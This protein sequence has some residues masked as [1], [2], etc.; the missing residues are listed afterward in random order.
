MTYL[1]RTNVRRCKIL[2][3][4]NYAMEITLRI[5]QQQNLRRNK[6]RHIVLNAFIDQYRIKS[7]S[8]RFINSHFYILH[9]LVDHRHNKPLFVHEFHVIRQIRFFLMSYTLPIKIKVPI[10]SVRT[11]NV[12]VTDSM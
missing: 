1:I 12:S 11:T 8:L 9:L 2:S 6:Y 10:I 5:L 7:R 4:A 3:D